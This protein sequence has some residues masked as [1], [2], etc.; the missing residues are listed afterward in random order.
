MIKNT[1]RYLVR[2]GV[3]YFTV[4]GALGFDTVAAVT[5]INMR[6]N[7]TL[8]DAD[9]NEVAIELE[10]AVPC[11]NQSEKWSLADRSLYD[12]ILSSADK[13]SVLSEHYTRGCMHERNRYMVDKS[14]FCVCYVTQSSGGSYY[15]M[16]YAKK[17]GLEIIN[18]ARK[19]AISR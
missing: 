6:D 1:V 7:E 10:V 5:V 11:R 18:L 14:S 13:V 2:R 4:G 16:S 8:L 15:T 12:E 19:E 9:G 17:S 3:R